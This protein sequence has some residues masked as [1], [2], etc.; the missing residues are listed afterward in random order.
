MKTLPHTRISGWRE[1]LRKSGSAYLILAICTSVA[2]YPLLQ[3]GFS[4][5]DLIL[6]L[7]RVAEYAHL[8]G[9]GIFPVRWGTDLEGG[10]GYPIYNFFPPLFMIISGILVMAAS[11]PV[12]SAVKLTI[13]LLTLAGGIGMY[14]FAREHF[15]KQGGLLA[16]CLYILAPYH[17]IDVFNRNAFSEFT[18]LAIAPFVFY[19]LARIAQE[20]EFKLS[21]TLVLTVS[22]S[23][24]VLSHNLS[25]IMY[26]PLFCVYFMAM[27]IVTGQW[28]KSGRIGLPL[29]LSFLLT[30]FYTLPLL[31]EIQFVQTWMLLI[32]RF[33]VL[34]NLLPIGRMTAWLTIFSWLLVIASAVSIIVWRRN[35][36]RPTLAVLCAFGLLLL[37]TVFMVTPASRPLWS[38]IEFLKWLQF[39][40]RLLSPATFLIC[41]AAGTLAYA[42]LPKNI[43]L[44]GGIALGVIAL[45]TFS[46][47]NR[48]TFT[49]IP[50]RE[51]APQNIRESWLP[52]TVFSEY[53][54]IWVKERP[55]SVAGPRLATLQADV[56]INAVEESLHRHAYE[57]SAPGET[58][59]T[60]RIYYFPGWKLHVNGHETQPRIS[61]Q[62]LMQF[63]V[64][65]GHSTV[66]LKFEDTPVRTA[67]N[68]LSLLGL[69]ILGILLMLAIRQ[70]RRQRLMKESAL[71]RDRPRRQTTVFPQ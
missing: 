9:S 20:D 21:T 68:R 26:A 13:F 11:F 3:A 59:L 33:N 15:E 35:I 37:L 27:I 47:V 12:M 45:M 50:D 24:F 66:E 48:W 67:G 57:I 61:S 32:G 28:K 8:L 10:Y 34:E 71:Y 69:L 52:T 46:M 2:T 6:E 1:V 30:A 19:G 64:P 43:L 63:H 58:W 14:W 39:P 53:L 17:F 18:A 60:A 55:P 51:L 25:I 70:S 40:W 4:Q 65:R 29:A 22:S 54:P 38:Q 23:L 36:P 42:P 5:G 41:F 7:T 44:Y 16:A 62:G 56:E 49:S 31:S